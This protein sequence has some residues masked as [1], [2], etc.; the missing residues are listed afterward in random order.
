MVFGAKKMLYYD[1]N[2]NLMGEIT[3]SMIKKVEILS[4][5]KFEVWSNL[6]IH[7]IE[8]T[9]NEYNMDQII[10]FMETNMNMKEMI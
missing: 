9:S 5:R 1:D 6:K 7:L 8:I 4:R 10:S 2:M 3:C